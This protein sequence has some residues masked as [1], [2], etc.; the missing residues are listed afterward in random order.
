M[1]RV[2][3]SFEAFKAFVSPEFERALA[4]VIAFLLD[5]VTLDNF[6][7]TELVKR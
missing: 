3:E 5:K 7:I 2:A 6:V 4:T 1:E